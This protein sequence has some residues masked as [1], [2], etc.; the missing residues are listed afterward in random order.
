MAKADETKKLICTSIA[1]L[2]YVKPF[3]KIKIDEVV[4]KAGISR[5][6]FYVHFDS[7]ENAVLKM[8]DEIY[9]QLVDLNDLNMYS[10]SDEHYKG[11]YATI[12]V[13]K[14]NKTAFSALTG[15]NGDIRFKMRIIGR[16]REGFYNMMVKKG[17]KAN[18]AAMFSEI[19]SSGLY[20]Q[21]KRI[22]NKSDAIEEEEIDIILK[23]INTTILAITNVNEG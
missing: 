22:V 13:L 21:S 18:D 23:M 8:E 2:M 19:F 7:V 20:A 14:Q 6:T 1:E 9:N 10:L 11:V 3:Y 16:L 4:Q 12:N 17:C 15:L 5:S